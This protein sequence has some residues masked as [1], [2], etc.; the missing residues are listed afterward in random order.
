M[1]GR[2]GAAKSFSKLRRSIVSRSLDIEIIDI[3]ERRS[4]VHRV[5]QWIVDEWGERT[6]T[7]TVEQLTSPTECPT[8]LVAVSDDLPVGVIGFCRY[9]REG[10][11]TPS[12]WI[13]VLYV[14]IEFRN[15]GIGTRLLA[16]A[17]R[18][19]PEFENTIFVYTATPSFYEARGWT[20]IDHDPATNMF[21]LGQEV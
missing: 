7:E 13:N 2:T 3:G 20:R 5:A 4:D 6:V 14:A 1:F 12:L 18:R 19:A 11:Q 21:V 10:E 16:E 8:A 9:Q 15:H 17:L